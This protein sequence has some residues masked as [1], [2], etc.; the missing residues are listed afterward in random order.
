[1]EFDFVA[2]VLL[3]SGAGYL[4]GKH[5][6]RKR[7]QAAFGNFQR[8]LIMSTQA[9]IGG[10]MD[11]VKKHLPNLETPVLMQEIVDA[12]KANGAEV[13]AVNSATGHVVRGSSNDDKTK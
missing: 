10:I 3:S 13:V 4:V 7:A 6:E 11:V 12:C 5:Y 8:H 9:T 2:A 1:M